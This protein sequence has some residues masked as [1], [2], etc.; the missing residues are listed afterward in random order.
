VRAGG[1][2]G[3]GTG[4]GGTSSKGPA[5]PA[6]EQARCAPGQGGQVTISYDPSTGSCPVLVTVAPKFT[7]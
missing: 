2:G 5:A 4:L 3:T 7:G 6:A 1:I